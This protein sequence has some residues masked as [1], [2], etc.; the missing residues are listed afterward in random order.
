MFNSSS[1]GTISG[2]RKIQRAILFNSSSGG[3][4]S[5]GIATVIEII[6]YNPIASILRLTNIS[7]SIIL[8]Y[9]KTITPKRT[10]DTHSGSSTRNI[11]TQKNSIVEKINITPNSVPEP[12]NG[13]QLVK[14]E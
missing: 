7:K 4:I 12:Q 3:L 5:N 11:L 6:S 1:G 13:S 2:G 9:K 8:N 10:R 14:I